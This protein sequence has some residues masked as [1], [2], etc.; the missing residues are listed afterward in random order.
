MLYAA[1]NGNVEMAKLLI[2]NGADINVEENRDG[3]TVLMYAVARGKTEL[4]KYM[5]AKGVDVNARLK[6]GGTALTLAVS[7]GF[8]DIIRILKDAGAK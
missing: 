6:T 5:I 4:V 8:S 2:D 7:A 3:N 1:F